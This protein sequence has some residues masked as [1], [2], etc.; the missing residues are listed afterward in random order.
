MA[1]SPLSKVR[2]LGFIT[3]NKENSSFEF[4][5]DYLEFKKAK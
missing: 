2:Y 5:V 3:S 4:E 1:D